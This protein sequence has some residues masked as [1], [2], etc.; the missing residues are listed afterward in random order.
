[1]S[2]RE[3]ATV[4]KKAVYV[5]LGVTTEGKRDV[6]GL[7][8][9]ETEG[10]RFWLGILTE[11]KNRGVEDIFFICCDGLTGLPQAN[12]SGLPTGGRPDVHCA[13]DSRITAPRLVYGPQ[14]RRRGPEAH[15]QRRERSRGQGRSRRLRRANL[16]RSIQHRQ[17]LAL[18]LALGRAVP[19]AARCSPSDTAPARRRRW[20]RNDGQRRSRRWT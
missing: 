18:A 8:F 12:R 16:A 11:L 14:T 4:Q 19:R 3:G 13:H 10:A 7:W 2:I 17:T 5:A 20:A 15:L 6:L 1:M 9:S